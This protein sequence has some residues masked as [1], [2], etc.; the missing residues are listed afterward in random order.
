MKIGKK[1][2]SRSIKIQK[3]LCVMTRTV[4]LPTLCIC[5]QWSQQWQIQ[6]ICSQSDQ[7]YYSLLTGSLVKYLCVMTRT[8]NLPRNIV[9]K[10]V[11]L[12][13]Y[14]CAMTRT[15][16]LPNVCICRQWKQQYHNLPTRW[17]TPRNLKWN[18]KWYNQLSCGQYQRQPENRLGH[19]LK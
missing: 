1:Q 6:G 8:V 2:A 12:D 17:A 18:Q 14:L 10:G 4:N 11:K 7:Q 19:S 16:N 3:N 5:S 13:Q 9:M 15:V